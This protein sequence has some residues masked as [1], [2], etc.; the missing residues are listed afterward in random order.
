M[1]G[2]QKYPNGQT[3]RQTDRCDEQIN[4]RK[5]R[6]GRQGVIN[7]LALKQMD[8]LTGSLYTVRLIDNFV[9]GQTNKEDG[10][11][12]RMTRES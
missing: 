3:D 10:Q 2:W 9:D 5:D 7:S 6:K 1:D 4:R 12:D 11:K 8:K